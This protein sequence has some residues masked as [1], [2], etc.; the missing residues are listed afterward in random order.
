MKRQLSKQKKNTKHR[1][2][3]Q[4]LHPS[5]YTFIFTVEE[6][7]QNRHHILTLLDAK[8]SDKIFIRLLLASIID[9]SKCKS[10]PVL[11]YIFILHI[12]TLSFSKILL[13]ISKCE[14]QFL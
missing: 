5:I 13:V 10:Q 4:M 3:A 1:Y 9:C 11:S 7:V 14:E 6:A 8:P 12:I 2:Y